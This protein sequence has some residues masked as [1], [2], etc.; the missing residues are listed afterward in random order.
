M[1]GRFWPERFVLFKSHSQR[2]WWRNAA[3]L[4]ARKLGTVKIFN[5]SITPRLFTTRSSEQNKN[6]AINSKSMINTWDLNKSFWPRHVTAVLVNLLAEQFENTIRTVF[7][8]IPSYTTG[9]QTHCIYSRN[10]FAENHTLCVRSA[11]SPN[12]FLHH[13]E[14]WKYVSISLRIRNRLLQ[15]IIFNRNI[16]RPLIMDRLN[17][18]S[19]AK[20][21]RN[22]RVAYSVMFHTCCFM[23]HMVEFARKRRDSF[24]THTHTLT[25]YTFWTSNAN[26]DRPFRTTVG[27]DSKKINPDWSWTFAALG[28]S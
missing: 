16:F 28:Y 20:R 23:L 4:S 7:F 26:Y 27:S 8:F 14:H 12:G 6:A 22:K 17:Y 2:V 1:F 19:A 13:V 9:D 18:I 24:Y 21:T 25:P 3:L 15:L 11:C 5:T 10:D